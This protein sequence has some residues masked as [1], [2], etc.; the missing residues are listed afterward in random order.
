[1]TTT[2]AR[3]QA[4]RQSVTRTV[5]APLMAVRRSRSWAA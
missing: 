2:L 4:S 5:A 3:S 1:M